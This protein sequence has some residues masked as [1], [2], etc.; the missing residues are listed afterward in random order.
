MP[1]EIYAL[2]RQ[3]ILEKKQIHADHNG[4]RRETCPHAIGRKNGRE[5]VLFYEHGGSGVERPRTPPQ[6]TWRCVSVNAL[7]N[8]TI[9]DGPW[10]TAKYQATNASCFDEMDI[11]VNQ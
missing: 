2:I 7:E 3:A 9:H 5:H 11:E 8:V 10:H 1:S 4:A 6:R